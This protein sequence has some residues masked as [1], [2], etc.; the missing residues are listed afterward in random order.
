MKTFLMLIL[1]SLCLVTSLDA[2]GQRTQKN[3]ATAMR[4]FWSAF[5][6]AVARNDKEAVASMTRFP[7][8]MPY[9]VRSIKTKQQLMKRYSEIFDAETKKCFSTA[10]P[11]R[12]QANTKRFWIGC[13]EAMM[14]W[15]DVVGGEYKFTAVDNVNE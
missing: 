6:S 8:E 3:T 14:Y 1:A 12:E 2:S 9:G 11:E 15:F 5:Q 4:T 10:K 7:L 13:G